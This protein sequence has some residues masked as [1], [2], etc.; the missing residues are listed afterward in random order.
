MSKETP[1]RELPPEDFMLRRTLALIPLLLLA[2]G[3]LVQAQIVEE[4]LRFGF[5]PT[6]TDETMY[7]GDL[8]QYQEDLKVKVADAFLTRAAGARKLSTG[9]MGVRVEW[10]GHTWNI[11]VDPGVIE[12]QPPPMKL[13]DIK[14]YLQP[15][16]EAFWST[17]LATKFPD[18]P[19][20]GT[21]GHVHLDKGVFERDPLLLRNLLVDV[22]NRAYLEGIFNDLGDHVN[23]RTVYERGEQD[24]FI[25]AVRKID[26]TAASKGGKYEFN[27][28]LEGLRPLFQNERYRDVNLINLWT[29]NPPTVEVRFLCGQTDAQDL[30]DQARW[31]ARYLKHLEKQ[32]RPLEPRRFTPVEREALRS[33]SV[34]ES[35]FRKLLGE[36]GL[37]W[38]SYSRWLKDRFPKP[39]RLERK[40]VEVRY[41]DDRDGLMSYE[42]RVGAKVGGVRISGKPVDL[43]EVVLADGT[44]VRVGQ[45]RM[46]SRSRFKVEAL[47]AK[48]DVM[49]SDVIGFSEVAGSSARPDSRLSQLRRRLSPSRLWEGWSGSSSIRTADPVED[50]KL[51]EVLSLLD[52]PGTRHLADAVRTREIRVHW[53]DPRTLGRAGARAGGPDIFLDRTHDVKSLAVELVH[54]GT[55]VYGLVKSGKPAGEVAAF[56]AE[57]AFARRAGLRSYFPH[58]EISRMTDAELGR[59]IRARW[60]ELYGNAAARPHR[61]A[62]TRLKG[63]AGRGAMGM[64]FF[65]G[66]VILKETI[67]GLWNHDPGRIRESLRHIASPSFV[68]GFALFTGL[69][70]ITARGVAAVGMRGALA[71]VTKFSLP[72]YAGVGILNALAGRRDLKSAAVDAT[73]FGVSMLAMMPVKAALR[74]AVY[75][76]LLAAGPVGWVGIAA[77]EIGQVALMLYG[78]EKLTPVIDKALTKTWAGMR[79]IGRGVSQAIRRLKFW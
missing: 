6:A 15:M 51:A 7:G 59:E 58:E 62:L 5:E 78:A 76:A 79:S 34:A 27:D 19:T 12:V 22:H 14:R 64:G 67:Q 48:G 61:A 60:P 28:V 77:L 55:H 10:E 9:Y 4:D 25:E 37:E 68:G 74:A 39:Y 26:R 53:A 56:R 33:P 46:S 73:S 43:T 36:L 65:A 29:N 71:S 38:K 20:W 11:D 3:S 24:A 72:L 49:A 23:A 32:G 57:A 54:E 52:R 17:N 50:A 40:G 16:Y 42:V 75:P 69:E 31:L 1:A 18:N 44:K 2:L 63:A 45:V 47:D 21:G 41:F 66:G 35:E 13:A 30:Y 70:Y 8:S